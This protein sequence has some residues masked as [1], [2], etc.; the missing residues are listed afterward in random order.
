[1]S[2]KNKTKVINT[3][4]TIIVPILIILFWLA[5]SIFSCYRDELCS[6]VAHAVVSSAPV[7]LIYIITL[8]VTNTLLKNRPDYIVTGEFS[9]LDYIL[10]ITAHLLA[11]FSPALGI[12]FLILLV[13]VAIY[14]LLPPRDKDNTKKRYMYTEDGEI[15]QVSLRPNDDD[16]LVPLDGLDINPEDISGAVVSSVNK[17]SGSSTNNQVITIILLILLA[18]L[19]MVIA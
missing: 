2:A 16:P 11:F 17:S 6:S 8:L 10:L 15:V 5:N 12:I 7:I 3:T 9:N 18:I 14:E 19:I 1:M 13:V 4:L